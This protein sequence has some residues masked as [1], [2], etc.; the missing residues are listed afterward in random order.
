[1]LSPVVYKENNH[2]C[3]FQNWN[4]TKEKAQKFDT[5]S[6]SSKTLGNQM[7]KSG[8]FQADLCPFSQLLC[9]GFLCF[10]L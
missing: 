8:H 6:V 7:N 10:F 2:K 3:T 9:D 4:N 5:G 1:M